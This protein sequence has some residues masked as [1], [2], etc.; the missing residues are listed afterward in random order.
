M[1]M[2]RYFFKSVKNLNGSKKNRKFNLGYQF[3]N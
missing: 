1:N 3:K 2:L